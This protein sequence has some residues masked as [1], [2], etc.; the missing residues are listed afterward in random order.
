MLVAALALLAAASWG[1][2]D[3]LGGLKSRGLSPIA[4]L[5]VAQPIGL[6]LV[7]I[8]VAARGEGPPDAAVLWACLSAVLGTIGL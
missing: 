7:G 6:A 5:I 8:W 2:G 4:I 1:V 3:F